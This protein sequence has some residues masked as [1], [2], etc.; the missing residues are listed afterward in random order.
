[1]PREAI[2][3]RIATSGFQD[4]FVTGVGALR[5]AKVRL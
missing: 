5:A 1:M 4:R 2:V 3:N